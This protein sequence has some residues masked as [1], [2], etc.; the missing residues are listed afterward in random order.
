MK[1][2]D[3]Q[4][5]TTDDQDPF[6][7]HLYQWYCYSNVVTC[8]IAYYTFC[9]NIY[10]TLFPIGKG[11]KEAD[12]YL[13]PYGSVTLELIS[14]RAVEGGLSDLINTWRWLGKEMWMIL[15]VCG[16]YGGVVMMTMRRMGMRMRR[17]TMRMT[18]RPC[19]SCSASTP[20]KK[21]NFIF[22]EGNGATIIFQSDHHQ[23][24]DDFN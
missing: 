12:V 8:I 11:E 16:L 9:T 7:V 1:R 17:M 23:H 10:S 18:P 13:I 2:P 19:T 20:W 21:F 4:D 15:C 22:Q 24:D 6:A 14:K 5:G 3:L